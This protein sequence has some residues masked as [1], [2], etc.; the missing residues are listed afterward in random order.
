M[1]CRPRPGNVQR[2]DRNV[3]G[4]ARLSVAGHPSRQPAAQR[5]AERCGEL[6]LWRISRRLVQTPTIKWVDEVDPDDVVAEC[7]GDQPGGFWQQHV[8]VDD[9]R[10]APTQLD[11][12]PQ[13]LCFEAPRRSSASPVCRSTTLNSVV[14][15]AV[16]AEVPSR[17]RAVDCRCRHERVPLHRRK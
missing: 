15:S 17:Y 9:G 1:P 4:K 8:Q 13:P 11:D 12:E 6:S 16:M 3:I 2:I 7:L 14:R 10:D 5:D